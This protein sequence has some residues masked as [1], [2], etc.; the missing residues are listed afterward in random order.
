MQQ[1]PGGCAGHA[2]QQVFAQ[3]WSNAEEGVHAGLSWQSLQD[4]G[5]VGEGH[6]QQQLPLILLRQVLHQSQAHVNDAVRKQARC[7]LLLP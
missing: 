1:L 5:H 6:R 7:T 3:G 2:E 4:M